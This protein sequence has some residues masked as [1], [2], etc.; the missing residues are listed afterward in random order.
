MRDVIF[1]EQ[2][3]RSKDHLREYL[4]PNEQEAI[5]NQMTNFETE[6]EDG[7]PLSSE[8]DEAIEDC[9][10]VASIQ[11]QE[12][13]VPQHGPGENTELGGAPQIGELSKMD[14]AVSFKNGSNAPNIASDRTR[15]ITS[16]LRRPKMGRCLLHNPLHHPS[17]R[18]LQLL[19]R[20]SQAMRAFGVSSLCLRR[21]RRAMEPRA[22]E[23][24][25]KEL[26]A[27]GFRPR[28]ARS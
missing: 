18:C 9:I 7:A 2:E 24:K 25:A 19:S 23:L 15:L 12:E 17:G 5:T 6:E 28:S 3:M 20:L 11:P 16:L 21:E 1:N 10:Y 27:T 22:I 14:R 26:R 13:E 4:P 8:E